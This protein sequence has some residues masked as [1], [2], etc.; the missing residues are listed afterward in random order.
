MNN[1]TGNWE[2]RL[3]AQAQQL[4]T[5]RWRSLPPVWGERGGSGT[6]RKKALQK[7]KGNMGPNGPML[8]SCVLLQVECVKQTAREGAEAKAIKGDV[9]L[10]H[11]TQEQHQKLCVIGGC[12]T[13][14]CG[15][16]CY[17]GQHGVLQPSH[18]EAT[19]FGDLGQLSGLLGWRNQIQSFQSPLG[20]YY[21]FVFYPVCRTM[22]NGTSGQILCGGQE[23]PLHHTIPHKSAQS[24]YCHW[25][26]W[27][28]LLPNS[29]KM[30]PLSP[31]GAAQRMTEVFLKDQ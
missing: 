13:K 25:L 30:L 26:N 16:Q 27:F 4:L 5:P 24:E 31:L 3:I 7:P 23:F 15:H 17:L 9:I 19:R 6:S 11:F 14:P 10:V 1:D 18:M 8:H 12:W 20:Q 28:P 29:M 2:V 22:L 21:P